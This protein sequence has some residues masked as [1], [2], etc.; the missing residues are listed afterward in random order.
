MCHHFGMRGSPVWLAWLAVAATACGGAQPTPVGKAGDT[1]DDGAGE[2]A[3][4]SIKLLIGG[5]TKVQPGADVRVHHDGT[6]GD[7]YGGGFYGG[8]GYGGDP[9]GGA[10]YA[11]WT[12]PQWSYTTPNRVPTYTIGSALPGVVEGA[13]TW[14]GATPAKLKTS[15]GLIDNPTLRVGSDKGMRGVLVY[16]EHVT[17]GRALPYYGRPASVGGVVAKHGCA[18]LPAAQVVTP[19][20]ASL[21]IHGDGARAKVVVAGKTHDLQEGGV[22]SVEVKLGLTRIEGEAGTLSPAWVLAMET[23]YY[24]I[25]DDTGRFRIDELPVGTYDVTF[26]QA[27]IATAGADGA[28]GVGQPIITHRT[29]HIDAGKPTRLDVALH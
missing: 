17:V 28:I 14:A 7:V 25:T 6:G 2:L 26:W 9:Y 20:P 18:L 12:V 13:V 29:I 8:G 3:R 10:S 15:C 11:G 27:P 1:H 16:I 22:V 24:A 5:P 4:A 23:P 19:L 21:A